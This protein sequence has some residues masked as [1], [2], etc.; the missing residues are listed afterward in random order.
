MI[1]V[2]IFCL[3][4]CVFATPV[5]YDFS[6]TITEMF[7]P[8]ELL[9]GSVGEA[10]SGYLIYVYDPDI[11]PFSGGDY[12]FLGF[13]FFEFNGYEI[14]NSE[15]SAP[16]STTTNAH[17]ANPRELWMCDQSPTH[18]DVIDF[19]FISLDIPLQTG[20]VWC[21]PACGPGFDLVG[22]IDSISVSAMPV[23][24]PSSILLLGSG[25][26]GLVGFKKKF[27]ILM[28]LSS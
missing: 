19:V 23:P 21:D 25:L 16:W 7:D 12:S 27:K 20:S 17:E 8:E 18:G 15:N 6:G 1:I 9:P 28:Q 2:F 3:S 4:H 14:Q 11:E 13:Y 10:F 22:T 24:E 5:K 26:I